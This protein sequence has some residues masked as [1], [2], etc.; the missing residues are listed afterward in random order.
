MLFLALV[1]VAVGVG[2]LAVAALGAV[3]ATGGSI[4][5]GLALLGCF[6]GDTAVLAR[7]IFADKDADGRDWGAMAGGGDLPFS[8]LI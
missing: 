8:C 4:T 3:L 1:P 2:V 7:G 6:W 5:R